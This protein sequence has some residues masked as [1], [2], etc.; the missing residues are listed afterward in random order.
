MLRSL[1]NTLMLV[2]L[3]FF[4]KSLFEKYF[5]GYA[6]V[7]VCCIVTFN[8]VKAQTTIASE[9]FENSLNLFTPS[10]TGY[11]YYSGNSTTGDRPASSPFFTQ[12]SFG[13]G[14]RNGSGVLTSSIINTAS[15]SSVN[16]SFRLASFSIGS[17]GNG[18]DNADIVTVEVSPNGGTNFYSTVRVLGRGN[19]CWSFSGGTGI[20]ST[21]YD[22]N[23]ASVDFQPTNGDLNTTE[24][25]STVSI[26]NLPAVT[27]LRVRITLLNNANQ[28]LYVIDD[29]KVEGTLLLP[30]ASPLNAGTATITSASGCASTNF[31]LN[32]TGLTVAS[33][34]SYQWQS[35]PTG[36]AG[37]WTN[38]S[39]ANSSS[40][41]TSATSSTF[42]Q[43]V[44]SC[45]SDNSTNTTNSVSYTVTG[46]PCTCVSYSIFSATSI[47]DA[48]ITNVSVGSMNNSSAC[49][50]VVG[51][52]GIASRYSNYTSSVTGPTHQLGSVV[53]FSLTSNIC[54]SSAYN[55]G[56]Q[57]YIDWN[58]DG[59]FSDAGEQVYSASASTSGS[60]TESGTFTVPLSAVLG[61]TRMRV[62]NVEIAFPTATNYA[63]TNYTYGETEDYCFTVIAASNCAG[64]PNN[65]TATI[66]S[67]SGCSSTSF[68][69][70][71]TGTTVGTGI[72]YQ[73]QS[74]PTGL[75]GTWTNISGA[76]S[77]SLATNT[78]VTTYYQLVT[79]CSFSG[80]S[81]SSNVVSF[82]VTGS[83]CTC[84]N[85]PANYPSNTA[86]EDITNVTVGSLNNS[87]VCGA[88][89]PGA[90]S[91]AYRYSNYTGS[92]S[93][94]S[95]MLGAVVPFS[96]TMT[97]CDGNFGNFF[98]IY[99]DWNQ[100]GDFSDA[101]EQVY[102]QNPNVL[103]NQTA[104]G[105]FT[106]PLTATLGITRMRVV[107]NETSANTNN[108]AQ[109]VSFS[110]GETEDYCF[111]VTASTPCTGIPSPGNT[112]ASSTSV[113]GG[114]STT[115]SLQNAT[116]GSGV[117]Y[118]WYSNTTNSIIGGTLISGATNSTLTTTIS[119]PTWF[120]C[121]VTCAGNSGTSTPVQITITACNTNLY[122][123]DPCFWDDYIDDISISNLN[124]TNTG[125]NGG[126]GVVDYTSI[127][128]NFLQGG[129]YPWTITSGEPGSWVG[130]WIDFND[131]NS[132]GD[133]GEFV[134]GNSTISTL[135]SIS[136]NSAATQ[137]NIPAGAALGNHR[138]RV[139][140]VN[141]AANQQNLTTSCTTYNYGETHDYT[142]NIT[143]P[144]TAPSTQAS[145]GAYTSTSAAGTTVNWVRGNG[146]AGVIVVA[147]LTS[148]A[149]VTPSNG[150]TYT[151][152]SIFG[153]GIGSQLTGTGNFVV[154]NGTGT[155]VNVTGLA[156]GSNYTFTV[157]EYNTASTCY[158]IPGSSSAVST[159]CAPFTGTYSVGSGTIAGEAGH[160][161]TLT[162]AVADYNTR[163]ITGPL[164]FL[165]TD[166]TYSTATGE[167]FPITINSNGYASAVNT[168]TI[169]PNTG[170]NSTITTNSTTATIVLNGA[171][172]V[173][174]DGSNS[175]TVNSICPRVQ[176]TRNLTIINTNTGTSQRAVVWLQTPASTTNGA[177]NNIIRN[178]IIQGNSST[179]T[180]FGIGSAD[181]N[182][183]NLDVNG[184]TSQNNNSIEN[185]EVSKVQ[186]GIYSVGK[187]T[188]NRNS[189][190]QILLND[191]FNCSQ[192]GIFTGFENGTIISGN[193]ISD[194]T[195]TANSSV[196]GIGVGAAFVTSESN[197]NSISEGI[198]TV[199]THNV[200]NNIRVSN[201]YS[202]FGIVIGKSNTGTT[203]ISNNMISGI[204]SN[205][206]IS[207]GIISNYNAGIHLGGGTA[208]INLYHNTIA[209]NG[210]ITG[211]TA[212]S[213]TSACVA[214]CNST[215]RVDAKN[216]ILSN[217]QT[218]NTNA[219]VKFTCWAIQGSPNY[220]QTNKLLTSNYNNLFCA[221]AGP[222]SYQIGLTG[223]VAAGAPRTSLANWQTDCAQDAN[224]FNVS[225]VFVSAND[226]HLQAVAGNTSLDN[227][228]TNLSITNDIDCD[229]RSSTPDIGADEFTISA[230]TGTPSAGV[231]SIN[232]S[233]GCAST[234]INL[235]ATGLTVAGGITYQ[236][237]SSPTGLPGTWTNISGANA[238]TYST[239]SSTTIYYQ[240]VT[241]CSNGGG[242]NTTNVVSFTVT[243]SPC[244][245]LTYPAIYANN[246]ADNDLTS[247]TV[248]SMTNTSACGDLAPGAG[249]IA[250]RYSNYTGSVS[251][252]SAAQ[253]T[254]VNFSLT[255][256]LCPGGSTNQNNFLIYI[257]WNQD[258]D[259]GDANEKVFS[260]IDS[261][262]STGLV[263]TQTLT[264]SFV[265][266]M[267]ALTGVTRMRVINTGGSFP[268]S[269]YAQT[270]AY[271]QGETE[272]YCFTVASATGPVCPN[273]ASIAP[274]SVQTV[275]QNGTTTQLTA[276][277]TTGGV[278]GTP[279][280]QYQWYYNT[281]NS[282]TVAG[283]TLI[284]GEVAS[285][286]TPPAGT[287]GT[288][289]Y[290]CV[291]YATDNGCNQTN[292][293]QSLASNAVQ[294]TIV[295]PSTL[296]NAS[297]FGIAAPVAGG[298]AVNHLV[299]SQVYGGG[300]NTSSTYRN[301]FIEL[302]N[303]TSA[304]ITISSSWSVQFASSATWSVTPLTNVTI[305]AGGYYLVQQAAGTSGTGS[306]NLPTPDVIGTI[307]IGSS[308]GK[309]LLATTTTAFTT[310]CPIPNASIVDF[311][312]W[313]TAGCFEGTNDAPPTSNP[314]ASIRNSAGC[315]D[316]D[317]NGNDFSTGTPTPRNS[318]SPL[319]PCAVATPTTFCGS[320]TPGAMSVTGVSGGSSY[321]YQWYSQTGLVSCPT[322]T[323]TSGW[324]LIP[325]A[326]TATYTPSSAISASTT[327]ACMV[328]INGAICSYT[329][330]ATSCVQITI[331]PN[332]SIADKTAVIC[333]GNNY[334]L[335]ASVGDVIP[336]GTTYTWTFTDNTNVT[337]ESNG[338]AQSPFSQTISSSSTATESVVYNVTSTNGTCTGNPFS[339]TIT[340]PKNPSVIFLSPP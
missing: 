220:D 320:G 1:Q 197:V 5:V 243:G 311:L 193:N 266:P 303:P 236:W 217:T 278:T 289:Y 235:S 283:A 207:N 145:I 152:N 76:N 99:V 56:F 288:R 229:S 119:A 195:T 175:S 66:T 223:G 25:Y 162:A 231:A 128:V 35:S 110:Y 269:N 82:T 287:I 279:T 126:T 98:Q 81:S 142:A 59:D 222:G 41:T 46:S 36:L 163:C 132:F 27:D 328:T 166:P 116:A 167:T 272:D 73:W 103:G 208:Q 104:T 213:V 87:S 154:Y 109:S 75:A 277:Y 298:T 64:V 194:I 338:T 107:N 63:Q 78:S 164:V 160:Y 77:P 149:E 67:S 336:S 321:S 49:A 224:S 188:S 143:A 155:S 329:Q 69:L 20:A 31:T 7:F 244:T 249:S 255:E 326:N 187:S 19:A 251:G 125:C 174:I 205:G 120:Y 333:S 9:P 139:R 88:L 340:I 161:N 252:P 23:A 327:Y 138:M 13:W 271:T 91:I 250:Y 246:T 80:S 112:L 37:T 123:I 178:C 136:S 89:A 247:V 317:N 90:G 117:T 3:R 318:A 71:T 105:S 113:S 218:G 111:T 268:S 221:G 180:A 100:D 95:E 203:T 157:Y 324:T 274:S 312:G 198:N 297:D 86:D 319:N 124:Q 304:P 68:T 323:S 293:T 44:T 254:S 92:V 256:N 38:I 210:T 330:W 335:A 245:C 273:S 79:T 26:S 291:V 54:T 83:P 202:A 300:N 8:S 51:T 182:L 12:G 299:I 233:N 339:V 21:A 43:L 199:I 2:A 204:R 313:N 267:T 114:G 209:M 131:N 16:L 184:G 215:F 189:G 241:T 24:G 148:T 301:D 129:S 102:S 316:T 322:G 97:T 191:V 265:V 156:S 11:T 173:T 85:Y 332:P 130:F 96:L 214:I 307:A 292:A 140:L 18:A 315:M 230:C 295:D 314:T 219:T 260:Q 58:Q 331:N 57:V 172:Y 70:N 122:N 212:A 280:V 248:G 118:Q 170:V 50:A 48:D 177:T 61:T 101:G 60:H 53:N 147:R 159:P 310:S 33:G 34:I 181:N 39:G 216:N 121:V 22:G 306:T 52:G 17:T 275:C 200:I 179:T 55:N 169:K 93:G 185:N 227:T 261:G 237:Q 190:T 253:G 168:L 183:L 334:T 165:L 242:T 226:L 309:V 284:V 47:Y 15:Y 259:F 29:F 296:Y 325:G 72:T 192:V 4:F 201:A 263:S 74:S 234:P 153:A 133:P 240:L 264:G 285:T 211:S 257:D 282:N 308:S 258:G 144:C 294:V 228:G 6:F 42:Y 262:P 225:P 137:V 276:T 150:T 286:F 84:L 158:L 281:T 151:A 305:P 32:A 186:Y 134:G 171:D 238:A 45:S 40:L 14:V 239:T 62:V 106:V 270:D 141:G 196:C 135:N 28:E 232:V 30:C 176:A 65:G 337:G 290:F 146:T 206:I 94:P 302:F 108:Y 115:L 10:G 127:I